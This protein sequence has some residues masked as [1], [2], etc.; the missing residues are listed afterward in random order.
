[1]NRIL[2]CFLFAIMANPVNAHSSEDY[3]LDKTYERLVSEMSDGSYEALVA[4]TRCSHYHGGGNLSDLYMVANTFLE[5]DP[6]LYG[7]ILVQEDVHTAPNF[8]SFFFHLPVELV[9]D[10]E[11]KV[12]ELEKRKNLMLNF[13]NEYFRHKMLPVFEKEIEQHKSWATESP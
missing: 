6:F 10:W 1:M 7:Y 8:K 9:D 2:L 4:F 12:K 13:D 3:C 11:G 5:K